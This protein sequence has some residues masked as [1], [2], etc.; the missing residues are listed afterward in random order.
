MDESDVGGDETP[1]PI[2]TEPPA[3]AAEQKR[4]SAAS[5]DT[6]DQEASLSR[7]SQQRKGS[8][9]SSSAPKSAMKRKAPKKPKSGPKFVDPTPSDTGVIIVRK[10]PLRSMTLSHH[11][12]H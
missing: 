8:A 6:E 5:M 2:I 1:T 10:D 12:L 9:S 7:N 11:L 3:A 4:P